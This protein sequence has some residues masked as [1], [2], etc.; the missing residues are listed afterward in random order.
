MLRADDLDK[1]GLRLK[2]ERRYLQAQTLPVTSLSGYLNTLATFVEED[3]RKRGDA[4]SEKQNSESPTADAYRQA[5]LEVFR[6][7]PA[8][9]QQKAIELYPEVAVAGSPLN[10]EFV[11]RMKRYQAEK[12]EFFDE[13]DWPIRL[14][15]ECSEDL[16]KPPSK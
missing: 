10:K 5:Q 12:K 13:P 15:K 1:E 6:K 2:A 16:A 7:N 4:Q 11:A 9:A 14:A 3:K 8:Q